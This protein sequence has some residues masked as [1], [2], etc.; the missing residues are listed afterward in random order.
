MSKLI[1][2]FL[3]VSFIRFFLLIFTNKSKTIFN[4]LTSTIIS[5]LATCG[6]LYPIQQYIN[7]YGND[8]DDL[9]IINLLLSNNRGYQAP[10]SLDSDL[11]SQFTE[12]L[13]Q[14]SSLIIFFC[15]YFIIIKN[16]KK[17][18]IDHFIRYNVMNGMLITL[19]STPI[20][21]LYI[22]LRQYLT[23]N[24]FLKAFIDDFCIGLILIHFCLMFYSIYFSI[25]NRYVNLPII[26]DACELHVGKKK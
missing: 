17:Y 16:G 7:Y 8:L 24:Q 9:P 25:T 12:K 15:I 3:L 10:I 23:I 11:L 13:S 18:K 20:S 21:Y 22:E 19:F 6:Y 2:L 1:I 26:G 4:A 5:F 14:Y